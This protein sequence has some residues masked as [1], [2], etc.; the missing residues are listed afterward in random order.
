VTHRSPLRAE[1]NVWRQR[2]ADCT[3]SLITEIRRVERLQTELAAE[4]RKLESRGKANDAYQQEIAD[5]RKE[6]AAARAE[7]RYVPVEADR[8]WRTLFHDLI[9]RTDD[10]EKYA[11]QI[12]G[13]AI[14]V[15]VDLPD[16]WIVMHLVDVQGSDKTAMQQ[17]L[18]GAKQIIA[19][20]DEWN[21]RY[22][23]GWNDGNSDA[24][25]ISDTQGESQQGGNE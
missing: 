16:D 13:T 3:T 7:R 18:A 6:L 24:R 9:L 17:Y 14:N 25:E 12:R 4:Q 20:R 23:S 8:A 15:T 2:H 10:G 1:S 22:I 11:L 21:Q 5:L 19:T